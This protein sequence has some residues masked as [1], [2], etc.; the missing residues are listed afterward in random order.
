MKLTQNDI[1]IIT[2]EIGAEVRD[3]YSGRGMVGKTTTAIVAESKETVILGLSALLEDILDCDYD[4]L[5][6]SDVERA[7]ELN[8]LIYKVSRASQDSMGKRHIVI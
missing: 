8:M 4:D 2:N 7:R 5:D 3:D 1:Y 6:Q